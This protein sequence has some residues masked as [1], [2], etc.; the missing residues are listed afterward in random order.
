MLVRLVPDI[1]RTAELV[2]EITAACREQDVGSS[3]INQAIQQLDQVTQQ[4]ASAS[5]EV[6]ATSEELTAQAEQLQRT[7]AYFRIDSGASRSAA[8]HAAAPHIALHH[9]TLDKA[10]A[11]LK[12]KAA[13]MRAKDAPAAKSPI[14]KAAKASHNGFAFDLHAGEDETDAEFRR[15]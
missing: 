5:E 10:V 2:G 11:Q 4:N 6:S 14:K 13:T 3:Q 7:I 1:R 8:P 15:A 9:G 12:T